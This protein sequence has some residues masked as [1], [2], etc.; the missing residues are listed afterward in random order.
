M[1]IQSIYKVPEGKLLKIYANIDETNNTIKDIAIN[2]DFFAYPEES[3][4]EL[5][6]IL[7][8][9]NFKKNDLMKIITA[10]IENNQVQFIGID[11][12]SLTEAIMRCE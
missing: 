10:F 6:K 3:I 12:E 5:E 11:A 1:K 2:G 8:Q 4:N 9:K 7:Q